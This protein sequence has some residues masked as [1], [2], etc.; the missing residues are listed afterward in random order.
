MWEME[1]FPPA[2]VQHEAPLLVHG[3]VVLRVEPDELWLHG[4]HRGANRVHI[5]IQ[6]HGLKGQEHGPGK[7]TR[8]FPNI[9]IFYF[10]FLK[11]NLVGAEGGVP[12]IM[13]LVII[14]PLFCWK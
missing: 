2:L 10:F 9:K 4:V 3:D 6:A 5:V 8:R 14:V 12:W 7:A 1:Y 11:K 13:I